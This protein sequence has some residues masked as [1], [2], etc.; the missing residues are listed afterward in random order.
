MLYLCGI[1]GRG[2]GILY[3]PDSLYWYNVPHKNA[4]LVFSMPLIASTFCCYIQL[5]LVC[6]DCI[7]KFRCGKSQV[8]LYYY[9]YFTSK[10]GKNAVLRHF[11]PFDQLYN[12]QTDLHVVNISKSS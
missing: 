10:C 11:S 8:K 9:P 1:G 6:F 5:I 7:L 12:T 2:R 4:K 3:R